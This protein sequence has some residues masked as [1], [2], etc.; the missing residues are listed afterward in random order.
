MTDLDS[1]LTNL[2]RQK[3]TYNEGLALAR[4]F[5]IDRGG[6]ISLVSDGI[7]IL[8]MLGEEAYCFQPYPDIDRF[9]FET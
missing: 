8:K 6:E 4:Q 9:Y 7:T 1:Y 5:V 3:K 2:R